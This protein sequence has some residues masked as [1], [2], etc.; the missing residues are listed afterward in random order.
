[1]PFIRAG[2]GCI[3]VTKNNIDYMALIGGNDGPNAYNDILYYNIAQKLWETTPI[4]LPVP[5]AEVKAAI[6]LKLDT[7][8]CNLVIL[9]NYPKC[10]L[11]ICEG[12]Y[13]WKWFDTKGM[14]YEW[15]KFA[16]VGAN[17]LLPCGI[18]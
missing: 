1:M 15:N 5:M 9:F 4:S 2:H 8:G 7:D 18:D 10:R 3:R 12:N 14:F 16:I 11:Y 13:N 17:G 6:S